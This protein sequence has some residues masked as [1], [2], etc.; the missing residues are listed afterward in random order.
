MV[1]L[2]KQYVSAHVD[3]FVP[4]G[5]LRDC[6]V[7]RDFIPSFSV[8]S[9]QDR[10]LYILMIGYLADVLCSYLASCTIYSLSRDEISVRDADVTIL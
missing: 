7:A 1:V 6:Y 3:Y 9:F 4:P 5:F 8:S 2:L 10:Y